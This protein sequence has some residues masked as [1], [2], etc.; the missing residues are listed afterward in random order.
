MW[1]SPVIPYTFHCNLALISAHLSRG[2]ATNYKKDC[3][4]VLPLTKEIKKA[5]VES[6]T[7]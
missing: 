1:M 6:F 3:E 7:K 2:I 5:F 4:V